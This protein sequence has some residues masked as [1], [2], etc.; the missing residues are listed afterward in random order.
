M[1]TEHWVEHGPI[2]EDEN[3]DTSRVSLVV[4]PQIPEAESPPPGP[5]TEA[6]L[7][8]LT[9]QASEEQR[10]VKHRMP[11][12]RE[13]AKLVE[14]MKALADAGQ[15]PQIMMTRRQF[16]DFKAQVWWGRELYSPLGLNHLF[17][18]LGKKAGK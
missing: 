9:A 5:L 2:V 8:E 14:Q 16:A 11:T 7:A 17:P 18:H 1:K 15:D 10:P 13:A 3:G 12:P 4:S 6:E